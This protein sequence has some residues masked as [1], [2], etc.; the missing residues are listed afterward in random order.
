MTLRTRGSWFTNPREG[1][2]SGAAGQTV[3]RRWRFWSPE[4]RGD[5]ERISDTGL[6]QGSLEPVSASPP[7]ASGLDEE[8]D[9][10]GNPVPFVTE[11][12]TRVR[13]ELAKRKE[14]RE[15]EGPRTGGCGAP[16]CASDACQRAWCAVPESPLSHVWPGLSWKQQERELRA[17]ESPLSSWVKLAQHRDRA[18]KPWHWVFSET[19]S[20]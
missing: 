6:W 19:S 11:L 15:R 14:V 16:G 3:G 2:P 17:L 8:G 20:C 1:C 12:S 5:P 13:Q 7:Q 10:R 4:Q 18:A 9:S